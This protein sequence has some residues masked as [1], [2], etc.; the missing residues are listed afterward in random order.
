MIVGN[1]AREHV[2]T[3]AIQNSSHETN[4]FYCA[5]NQNP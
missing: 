1:G 5:P 4:I 2:I 3:R